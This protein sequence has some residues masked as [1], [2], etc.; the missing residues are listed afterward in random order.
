MKLFIILSLLSASAF[1]AA[2]NPETVKV[3][4]LLLSNPK[5]TQELNAN[6]TVVLAD[7]ESSQG[8]KMVTNHK[9]TFVRGGH[10]IPS[11]AIVEIAEDFSKTIVDGP[12]I[13]T[14][15]VTVLNAASTAPKKEQQSQKSI[16]C[17]DVHSGPDYGYF[18]TI[19]P[20]LKSATVM[21]QSI[22]GPQHVDDLECM[23]GKAPQGGADMIYTLVACRTP[24]LADA[25]HSLVVKTG[26]IA[27]LT[28]GK[29]SEVTFAGN[30]LKADLSCQ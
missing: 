26:G 13:Y 3:A 1:A 28:Q 17:K 25:G 9:L 24:N 11:T 6:G 12:V 29:L 27:G 4:G 18:V 5:V 15:K 20:D 16:I 30:K 8:G 19:S 23:P 2:P 14:S 22:A 10:T 7:L 21:M